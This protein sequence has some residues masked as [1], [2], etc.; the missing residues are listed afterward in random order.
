MCSVDAAYLAELKAHI[1]QH[2]LNMTPETLRSVVEHAFSQFQ[3]L[4]ENGGQHIE[5]VLR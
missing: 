4:A 3:L 5:H 1:A 2:I